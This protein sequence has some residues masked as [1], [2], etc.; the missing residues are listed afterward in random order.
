[1]IGFLDDGEV[2]VDKKQSVLML[3]LVKKFA[4]FFLL[5]D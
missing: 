1:M 5:E 2:F 3:G 4:D